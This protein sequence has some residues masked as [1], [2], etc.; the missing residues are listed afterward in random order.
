[1]RHQ[2][3]SRIV[4]MKF[5]EGDKVIIKDDFHKIRKGTVVDYAYLHIGSKSKLFY[6]VRVGWFLPTTNYY[7]EED[8]TLIGKEK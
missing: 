2:S 7:P 5:K 4:K 1:M 6:Y 8:L 3:I